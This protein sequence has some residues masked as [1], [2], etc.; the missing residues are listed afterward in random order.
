M[1]DMNIFNL[2]KNRKTDQINKILGT[3]NLKYENL[4]QQLL[5]FN[6]NNK[7]IT[8]ENILL[9]N[10]DNEIDKNKSSIYELPTFELVQFIFYIGEIFELSEYEEIFSGIGV[11]SRSIRNYNQQN[12]YKF[13]SIKSIDGNYLYNT[14]GYSYDKI[15]KKDILEYI[16]EYNNFSSQKRILHE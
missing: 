7:D 4:I 14:D 11:L 16:L 5:K 2:I 10:Y 15:I 1:N 6:E 13:K 12:H 8:L 3:E 9:N